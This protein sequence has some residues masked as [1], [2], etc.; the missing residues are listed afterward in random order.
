MNVKNFMKS[1]RLSKIVKDN[2]SFEFISGADCIWFWIHFD[3][4]CLNFSSNDGEQFH[5]SSL[6]KEHDLD[7]VKQGF[8]GIKAL[9][10]TIDEYINWE[11]AKP[12]ILFIPEEED[13]CRD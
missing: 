12:N 1:R 5:L 10:E 9:R 11:M 8:E 3:E 6:V 13:L 4:S 7:K 2:L